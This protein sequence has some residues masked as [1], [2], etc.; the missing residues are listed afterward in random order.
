MADEFHHVTFVGVT[1]HAGAENVG[2]VSS[3]PVENPVIQSY[4]L[5]AAI[6]PEIS[7]PLLLNI[8]IVS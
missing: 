1:I 4:L 2:E 8:V 3:T 5:P 6:P 7:D